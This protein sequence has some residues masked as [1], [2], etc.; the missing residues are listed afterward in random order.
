[1]SGRFV[2]ELMLGIIG[3]AIAFSCAP[4]AVEIALQ[5]IAEHDV[6]EKLKAI[7]LPLGHMKAEKDVRN[8]FGFAVRGLG[9][10]TCAHIAASDTMRFQPVMSNADSVMVLAEKL[11]AFDLAVYEIIRGSDISAYQ[12]GDFAAIQPYDTVIYFGWEPARL[13]KLQIIRA[14]VSATGH[15]ARQNESLAFIDFSGVMNPGYS[16][17]PVLDSQGR[18]IAIA[19]EC[20]IVKGFKGTVE[21]T[22]IRAFSLEP[23]LATGAD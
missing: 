3:L 12:L 18:V 8:G 19:S 15:V 14:V 13:P 17:G 2:K 11:D 4:T 22:I 5:E 16:G 23:L 7:V 6:A 10:V 1:M 9:I 21:E 20:A